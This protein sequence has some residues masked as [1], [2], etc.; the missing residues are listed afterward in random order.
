MSVA[1]VGIAVLAL[2]Q[3]PPSLVDSP[4]P[5]TLSTTLQNASGEKEKAVNDTATRRGGWRR[6]REREKEEEEREDD[7]NFAVTRTVGL[8]LTYV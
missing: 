1:V 2:R 8:N 3:F 4:T 6:R 7:Y 5:S